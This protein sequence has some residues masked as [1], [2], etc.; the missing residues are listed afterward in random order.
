[1]RREEF[2]QELAA[3]IRRAV[4]IDATCWHGLDPRT[5]MLTSANP[6]ELLAGGFMT[7]ENQP[8]AAW[9]VLASEYERDDH[10]TFASI[11]RRRAPVG[12]LGESTRGRPERSA[13]YREFLAPHGTPF[14]L[15]AAFV[16]RG[17]AWGCVVFHRTAA[18]GDFT[19][20]EA[21]VV[22]RLSRP[23][24][25][26]LRASIRL[27]AARR[28]DN[29]AAPGLVLLGRRDEVE[30]V[31]P[32]ARA[33]L[34]DLAGESSSRPH[35][36]PLPLP[37]LAAVARHHARGIPDRAAP[38]MDVPTRAGWV[39]L[40]ASVPDGAGSDRVAIVIQRA[41]PEAAIALELEAYGLTDREREVAGLAVR[42]FSTVALAEQLH[43]SP[44]TIQDHFKSIFEKTGTRSRRQLRALV[45]FE[46]YLPA[47][48]ARRPLD[49]KGSLTRAGG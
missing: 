21:G 18:T 10:N 13:R 14:E 45:F 31:T 32:P 4:P 24:A 44:W 5:L 28:C 47:I 29:D 43:L 16:S 39:S 34:D 46:E 2:H 23:I 41:A 25:E 30:L 40:H 42:G 7:L 33:L 22:A 48:N 6:V 9:S 3:R 35:K 17:R 8:A 49:A 15:R 26:G 27:D 36:V 12:I 37:S 20:R 38:S 1:M 11:A 19:H